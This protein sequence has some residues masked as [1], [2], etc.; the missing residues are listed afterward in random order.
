MNK[1]TGFNAS[2]A[3][4]A[5]NQP[6]S[7][8]RTEVIKR[9]TQTIST[10][11]IARRKIFFLLAW[12]V[13]AVILGWRSF[14]MYHGDFDQDCFAGSLEPSGYSLMTDDQR[15]SACHTLTNGEQLCGAALRDYAENTAPSC[16]PY[17]D[18]YY[19]SIGIGGGLLLALIYESFQGK[20]AQMPF[21]TATWSL[22]FGMFACGD[23]IQLHDIRKWQYVF[24][25]I[26]CLG[27]FAIWHF[28]NGD[29]F[30]SKALVHESGR[31]LTGITRAWMV[32]VPTCAAEIGSIRANNLAREHWVQDYMGWAAKSILNKLVVMLVLH[33]VLD[34]QTQL[35]W[36]HKPDS[37]D[38]QHSQRIWVILITTALALLVFSFWY[39]YLKHRYVEIEVA[40][41]EEEKSL[42]STDS[43]QRLHN[44]LWAYVDF[45]VNLTMA[46]MVGYNVTA[47]LNDAHGNTHLPADFHSGLLYLILVTIGIWNIP[48]NIMD[49]N[50]KAQA[51]K[52]DMEEVPLDKMPAQQEANT[53]SQYVWS[54]VPLSWFFY[55]PQ[56]AQG[57]ASKFTE[58]CIVHMKKPSLKKVEEVMGQQEKD[59]L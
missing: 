51:E 26:S 29:S 43:V 49:A 12:F 25:L 34:P 18:A 2:L 44:R 40:P 52:E 28:I 58:S 20:A 53:W 8:F 23:E 6:F 1:Q 19:A 50:W 56:S 21:N 9:S 39:R 37:N 7:V 13:L 14:Y 57:Q 30:E 11:N 10:Y 31:T 55:S 24:H 47:R 33:F 3:I 35:L 59:N 17:G 22:D 15:A 46:A 36:M 4:T 54:L 41:T 5:N 32:V 16:N 27:Y 48:V 42:K 45:P 38:D